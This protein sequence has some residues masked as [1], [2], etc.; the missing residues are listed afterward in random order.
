MRSLTLIGLVL[1]SMLVQ[2]TVYK[3]IDKDGKVHY[4]DEPQPNAQVVELKEK[5]LNQIALPLPKADSNNANQAIESIQYKV[6]ITSPAEEETVRD[7][8]GDFDVV[9]TITPELKSQYL[10]V[11]KLDGTPVDQP[12]IGGT[13]KLKNIDRGEHTLVVDA[14]TQNGKVFASSSPRKIFLHQAAKR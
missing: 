10:M 1:F 9:A 13:F 12:Q 11:L 8:N 7:N 14:L 5:T 4:S 3:W 6:N 2:A